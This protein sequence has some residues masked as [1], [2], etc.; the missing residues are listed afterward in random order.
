MNNTSGVECV[1]HTKG[2]SE[3]VI[4]TTILH[5]ET[6]EAYVKIDHHLNKPFKLCGLSNGIEAALK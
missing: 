4:L 6:E 1:Q 3:P 2:F 5:N